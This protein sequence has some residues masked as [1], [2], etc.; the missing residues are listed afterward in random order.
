MK[1]GSLFTLGCALIS[2]AHA[3]F[4]ADVIMYKSGEMPNPRDVASILSR[5]GPAAPQIR[6]RGLSL[7]P[8]DDRPTAHTAGGQ[9]EPSHSGASSLALPVQFAFNS[10]NILPQ[11]TAQ[12]DAVAEGIKLA[13]PEVKVLIEGHTDGLGS[14]QY[15]LILSRRRAESVKAYLVEHHGIPAASLKSVGLGKA[16]PLNRDNPFASENR[17]VEFRA[18][19]A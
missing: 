9:K 4:A 14:D 16:A 12:L 13:G 17:R 7:L 5:R 1:T 8:D 18:A 3:A 11:A 19:D 15:N 6:T 2:L 10:A